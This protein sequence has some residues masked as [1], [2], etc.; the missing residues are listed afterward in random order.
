MASLAIMIGGALIN[1]T[2]FVGGSYLAKYLIG[3]QNSAEE[4]NK[5]HDLA[6]E[7]YHAAY[8]KYQENRTK[9]LDWIAINDRVKDQAKQN[10]V[11]TDYSLKLYNKVD[12]EELELSELQLSDFYKPSVQQKQGEMICVRGMALAL[13][14]VT[15]LWFG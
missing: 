5:I 8:E 15:A 2:A 9:L 12:N 14:L 6:V 7:K 3:E 11:D 10:F 4:E 13:G 1:A